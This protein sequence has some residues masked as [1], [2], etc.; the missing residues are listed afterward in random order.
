MLLHY[1]SYFIVPDFNLFLAQ[2]CSYET[3]NRGDYL[4][5]AQHEEPGLVT[6]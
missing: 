5:V 4:L 2:I 6:R 1:Y 3:K